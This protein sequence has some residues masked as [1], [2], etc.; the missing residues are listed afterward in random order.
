MLPTNDQSDADKKSKQEK[1]ETMDGGKM[2]Q[3]SDGATE[4]SERAGVTIQKWHTHSF[5]SAVIRNFGRDY[6]DIAI[7]SINPTKVCDNLRQA[8]RLIL[9]RTMR[10]SDPY[11]CQSKLSAFQSNL[12]H[13]IN[14]K[15]SQ[16]HKQNSDEHAH[17][18]KMLFSRILEIAILRTFFLKIKYVTDVPVSLLKPLTTHL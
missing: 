2:L 8:F 14:L 5:E 17:N 4:H 1:W 3:H 7:V 6:L 13:V 11:A 15:D 9:L 10:S 18:E 12:S 16:Q